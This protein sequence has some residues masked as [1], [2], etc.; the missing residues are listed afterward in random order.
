MGSEHQKLKLLYLM[1]MLYEQT[2]DVPNVVFPCASL[3]DA[4]TGRIAVYY[5]CADTVTGLAFTTVDELMAWMKKH[6]L[7]QNAVKAN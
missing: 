2:G 5:G 7:D 3:V 1:Q 4:A 6:P